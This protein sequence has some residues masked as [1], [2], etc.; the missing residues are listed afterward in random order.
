MKRLTGSGSFVVFVYIRDRIVGD[1]LDALD[2]TGCM[3]S[4]ARRPRDQSIFEVA[5]NTLAYDLACYNC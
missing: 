1:K 3:G 5:P 2:L 4:V